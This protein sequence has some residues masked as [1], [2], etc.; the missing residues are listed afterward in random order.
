M[1]KLVVILASLAFAGIATPLDAK[2]KCHIAKSMGDPDAIAKFCK[3]GSGGSS[4]NST[5]T[6]TQEAVIKA[7]AP[8]FRLCDKQRDLCEQD[9]GTA[10]Y[11]DKLRILCSNQRIGC[12]KD[13]GG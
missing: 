8:C 9:I 3:S 4:S 10:I 11:P 12:Q 6:E 5:S 7:R 1:R 13:C 2:N